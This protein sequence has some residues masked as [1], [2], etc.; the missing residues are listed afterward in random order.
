MARNCYGGVH[1]ADKVGAVLHSFTDDGFDS[2]AEGRRVAGKSTRKDDR[3]PGPLSANTDLLSVSSPESL[4]AVLPAVC[5][6][7][8]PKKGLDN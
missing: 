4:V 2:S 6:L 3:Y 5:T 1:F 8:Y 7:E